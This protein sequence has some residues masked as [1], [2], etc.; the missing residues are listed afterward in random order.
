MIT[1]GKIIIKN[2]GEYRTKTKE[3]KIHSSSL[4]ALFVIITE[5]SVGVHQIVKRQLCHS[6][7]LNVGTVSVLQQVLKDYIGFSDRCLAEHLNGSMS[8]ICFVGS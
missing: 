3:K 6:T 1:I 7:C 2:K 8:I 5:W 4:K